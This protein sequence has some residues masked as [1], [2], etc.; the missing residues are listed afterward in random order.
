[1]L[2]FYRSR[3]WRM[4]NV[5]GLW[6]ESI[7]LHLLITLM[8]LLHGRGLHTNTILCI[9][10]FVFIYTF[11]FLSLK[12]NEIIWKDPRC[13]VICFFT[14]KIFFL[15]FLQSIIKVCGLCVANIKG[16]SIKLL[17]YRVTYNGWHTRVWRPTLTIA[18]G[19]QNKPRTSG[20]KRP[21]CPVS[22]ADVS[23]EA[24]RDAAW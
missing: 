15:T 5:A 20:S 9:A 4:N 13:W 12:C 24:Q 7:S 21:P 23:H 14:K 16:H 8:A 3:K 11:V 18:P 19:C 1:M 22:H 17:L 2:T 6:V 10:S